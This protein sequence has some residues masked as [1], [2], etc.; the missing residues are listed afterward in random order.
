MALARRRLFLRHPA[1]PLGQPVHRR[2][3][4]RGR[5]GEQAECARIAL[6]VTERLAK[7]IGYGSTG[8]ARDQGRQRAGTL[9]EVDLRLD[10]RA[11]ADLA[12]QTLRAV[13]YVITAQKMLMDRAAPAGALTHD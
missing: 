5:S 9:D 13:G 2:C 4:D 12:K 1:R 11:R 8:F 10:A 6:V 3:V 7:G